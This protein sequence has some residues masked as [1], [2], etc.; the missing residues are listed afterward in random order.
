[1]NT[2]DPDLVLSL[3]EHAP[4][5]MFVV[6]PGGVIQFANPAAGTL[7]RCSLEDLIDQPI[8]ILVPKGERPQHVVSRT[9]FESAAR[10]RHMGELD[11]PVLA[12]RLDD[13]EFPADVMLVPMGGGTV[14]CVVRDMT[15]LVAVQREREAARTALELANAELAASNAAKA[16]VMAVA[17]HDLRNP[18][19][20]IRAYLELL[21]LRSD[22][23]PVQPW[24]F[25]LRQMSEATDYMLS[26]ISDLLDVAKIEE[27]NLRLNRTRTDV[28][29]LVQTAVEGQRILA[30][31]KHVTI[32]MSLDH[33]T[34]HRDLDP[35]RISQ[36]LQNLLS[37]AIK[38]SPLHA[39]VDVVVADAPDGTVVISVTDHG[40]GIPEA[41][42]AR[43]FHRYAVGSTRG[44]AGEPSTG[45]GLAIVTK[46][47]NEHGGRIWVDSKPGAGS[48]FHIALP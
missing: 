5:A 32:A 28:G 15:A 17:A 33:G 10:T 24:Q 31:A 47:V 34:V 20:V 7:F 36:V 19:T 29:E 11:D 13:T 37:N 1:M 27:G 30:H 12:L 21:K 44:T 3:V 14:L 22:S 48:T 42:V 43:M 16:E 39:T 4:D 45:L 41:E 26:L 6:G 40:A 23:V 46:I 18:L 35:M 25:A 38:F 9:E 8:E 2:P